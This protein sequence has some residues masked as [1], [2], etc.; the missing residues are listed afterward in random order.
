VPGPLLSLENEEIVLIQTSGWLLKKR[1]IST[2]AEPKISLP[3]KLDTIFHGREGDIFFVVDF[4]SRGSTRIRYMFRCNLF[5][6]WGQ[7]GKI[8]RKAIL[9]LLEKCF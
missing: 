3:G 6:Y 2:V 9:V 7:I 4:Y 8:A 1:V 5:V